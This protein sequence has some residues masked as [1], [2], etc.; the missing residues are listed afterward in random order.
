VWGART[1]LEPTD[2]TRR[3]QPRAVG[4]LVDL[5]RFNS[6]TDYRDSILKLQREIVRHGAWERFFFFADADVEILGLKR[7]DFQGLDIVIWFSPNPSNRQAVYRLRD[8]GLRVVCIGKQPSCG[9]PDYH[10]LSR[11]RHIGVILREQILNR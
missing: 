10:V 3:N 7:Q 4:L 6:T 1:S 5:C 11:R 2:T 8:I 9:I